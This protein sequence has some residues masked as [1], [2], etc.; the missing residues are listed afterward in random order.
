MD[1]ERAKSYS[2]N[3][4]M[5]VAVCLDSYE[6][7]FKNFKNCNMGKKVDC[8]AFSLLKKIQK[9]APLFYE[10]WRETISQVVQSSRVS[11]HGINAAITTGISYLYAELGWRMPFLDENLIKNI[12]WESRKES[13]SELRSFFDTDSMEVFDLL[14]P[15]DSLLILKLFRMFVEGSKQN[16]K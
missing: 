6:C 8:P 1:K 3:M 13:T 15:G 14:K 4:G 5:L 7:F 12:T 10:K 11:P 9:R 16:K 2:W